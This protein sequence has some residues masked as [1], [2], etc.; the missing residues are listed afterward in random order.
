MLPEGSI[1]EGLRPPYPPCRA[2]TWCLVHWGMF[3]SRQFREQADPQGS[4]V[5]QKLVSA[6]THLGHEGLACVMGKLPLLW[7][8]LLHTGNF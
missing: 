3:D 5:P 7:I 2:C 1:Q 8:R 4:P 6:L